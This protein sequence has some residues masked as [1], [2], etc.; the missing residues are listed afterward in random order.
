[1][2]DPNRRYGRPVPAALPA[3]LSAPVLTALPATADAGRARVSSGRV[4]FDA[5][6]G[7]TNDVKVAQV[8]KTTVNVTD[9]GAPV[10]TGTGCVRVSDSLARCTVR[11]PGGIV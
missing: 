3:A 8:G 5:F 7:E 6:P 9:N 4:I 1:M 11:N 2:T 10:T